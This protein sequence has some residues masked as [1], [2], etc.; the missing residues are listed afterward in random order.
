MTGS[1]AASR[2]CDGG[3]GGGRFSIP[4]H[5]GEGSRKFFS[6]LSASVWSKIKGGADPSGFSLGSA[7]GEVFHGDHTW[8]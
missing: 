4:L 5:K 7:S 8:G 2:P 6:T 1:S 3:G